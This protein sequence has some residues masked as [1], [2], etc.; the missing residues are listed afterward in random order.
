MNDIDGIGEDARRRIAEAKERAHFLESQP[1]Y[2]RYDAMKLVREAARL[3][4]KPGNLVIY[5]DAFRWKRDDSDAV[6]PNHYEMHSLEY[7]ADAWDYEVIHNF[8]HAAVV[9]QK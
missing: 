4:A 7:L 6:L 3:L 9:R 1:T 5:R 2:Q 8:C